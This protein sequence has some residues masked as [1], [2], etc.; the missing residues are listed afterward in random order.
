MK[1]LPFV[2]TKVVCDVESSTVFTKLQRP[3]QDI[4]WFQNVAPFARREG[5]W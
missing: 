5:S 2:R 1:S 4:W 3:T